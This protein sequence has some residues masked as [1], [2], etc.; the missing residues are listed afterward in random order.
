LYPVALDLAGKTCV[1][2]GGGAVA[3]R[4]IPDLLESDAQVILISP[5]I[6]TTLREMVSQHQ[7]QWIDQSY[8]PGSLEAL[9]PFLIIAA[10]DSPEINRQIVE[11]ARTIGALVNAVDGDTTSDFH[12]MSCLHRPPFTVA[13]HTDGVSPAMTRHLRA[14][15]DEALG[16][17]YITLTDWLGGLRSQIKQQ[18]ASQSQR[19]AFYDAVIQSEALPL[20]RQGKTEAAYKQVQ[21]LVQEW[22]CVR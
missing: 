7:L 15:I 2:V 13:I 9:N 3:T 12:N 22:T 11:N 5:E 17:E 14:V 16:E 19:R 6:T 18:I 4:K 10:T 21:A 8:Q 1:V 20:L